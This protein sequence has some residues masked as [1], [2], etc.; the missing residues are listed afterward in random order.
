MT[1][2]TLPD[3]EERSVQTLRQHLED[4]D[5]ISL[6]EA[7]EFGREALAG[8]VGVMDMAMLLWRV[9]RDQLR[10]ASAAGEE[11]HARI[12]NFLL[13]CLSPFEMAHRGAREANEAL[14]CLDERR[15][16]QARH[17]ARELHDQAG[18][19]LASV[20]LALGDLRPHLASGGETGLARIAGL[21]DAVEDE[22]RR[23]SHEL[24]PLVLDD[25]GLLPAL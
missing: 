20:H 10:E 14:R 13:E 3:L 24:R 5:E 11:R 18:Q 19:L 15:E 16:D 17:I 22:I 9:A 4:G 8:G 1:T 12:E 6:H 2:Q 21:L 7:Y 25:L 23:I